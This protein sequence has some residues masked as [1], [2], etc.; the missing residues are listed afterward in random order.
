[1]IPFAEIDIKNDGMY[2]K[3]LSAVAQ[4]SGLYSESSTPF[5]GY[6]AV[7]NIF[8]KSFN[9]TNLSRSDTAFDAKYNSTGIGL[10]TFVCN[11]TTK[12]EKIAE[13]NSRS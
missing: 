8:C 6:R 1:M 11:S 9:A 13:F 12:T 5:I 7:E 3:L 10:K 4:L 2:L